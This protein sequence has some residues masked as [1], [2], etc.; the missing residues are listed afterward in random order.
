MLVREALLAGEYDVS[1]HVEHAAAAGLAAASEQRDRQIPG[2][3]VASVHAAGEHDHAVV[4]QAAS[5]AFLDRRELAR[6]L[7]SLLRVPVADRGKA[8]VA[9]AGVLQPVI[10]RDT[11]GALR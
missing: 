6:E 4:E 1:V 7:R 2:V 11:T 9:V 3:V 8:I 10:A 5:L